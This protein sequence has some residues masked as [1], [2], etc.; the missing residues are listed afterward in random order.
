MESEETFSSVSSPDIENMQMLEAGKVAKR[1]SSTIEV[2]QV[3]A[4]QT[5]R[6]SK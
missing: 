6:A 2:S 5:S 1:I 4:D 3:S